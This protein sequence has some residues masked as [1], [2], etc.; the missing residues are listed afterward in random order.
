MVRVIPHFIWV[1]LVLLVLEV[2][3]ISALLLSQE[4]YKPKGCSASTGP[5]VSTVVLNHPECRYQLIVTKW[6]EIEPSPGVF[7]FSAL[8]NKINLVKQY[9]KKY[10]LAVGMGGPGSPAWLVDSLHVPFVDYKFR[11]TIPYKLPLWWDSTVQ[12]RIRL[13]VAKLGEEFKDDTSLALV[14]ITQMTANGIEGH[15]QGVNMDSMRAKGYTAEKWI[16]AAKQTAYYFANAFPTKALAFEIHDIEN[17]STIPIT[18]IS[19]LFNDPLLNHRIG[20]AIWWLS[21]KTT[22]QPDLLSFLKTFPGDKYAQ[23]IGHSGQPERFAD[24]TIATAFAQAKELN[25][26]YI[27][28]WY[29]EYSSRSIDQLLR[30]FNSWADSV[31]GLTEVYLNQNNVPS[32]FALYQN[33]PNPFNSSTTIRFS[34]PSQTY[35]TLK[36]FDILGREVTTLVD[37]EF[38]AG[39]HSVLFDARNLPSGIYFYQL[40]TSGFVGQR[41]M[42]II[43]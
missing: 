14:Y 33:Y 32:G 37:G 18:I 8:K 5:N 6:S 43:R 20:A 30:D 31:F 27:E 40:K 12:N 17:S 41:G 28:L 35:V 23:M 4:V 25:I 15:L 24:N 42:L 34:L 21:G 3:P 10:A 39:E 26:R 38:D 1:G 16:A 19:D 7:T 13:M 22:Y 2:A 11:G 36:V 29:E 9:N